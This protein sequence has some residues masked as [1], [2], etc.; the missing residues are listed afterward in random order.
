M[1]ARLTYR[2]GN[3]GWVPPNHITQRDKVGASRDQRGNCVQRL[4]VTHAGDLEH[5]RPPADALFYG[6]ER[7]ALS[8][9]VRLAEHHVV[10]TLLGGEHGIVPASQAAN[11]HDA[12]RLERFECPGEIGNAIEVRAVG[13]RARDQLE[14]PIK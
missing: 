11:T 13:A 3:T 12:L 9:R 14:A 10:G 5:V 8:G 4:A 6:R 7:R 1:A 2:F